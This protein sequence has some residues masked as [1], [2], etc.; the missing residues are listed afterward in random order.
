MKHGQKV[1]SNILIQVPCRG[2]LWEF[3]AFLISGEDFKQLQ[4]KK[5]SSGKAGKSTSLYH[6]KNLNSKTGFP[7]RHPS[8]FF[9]ID[10]FLRHLL[11]L[12]V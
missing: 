12:A 4:E 3:L 7:S 11:V 8:P 6:I 10:L 1:K 5:K 9:E 2:S